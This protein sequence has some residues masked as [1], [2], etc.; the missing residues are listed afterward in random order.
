M[1]KKQHKTKGFFNKIS[2]FFNKNKTD[3][4]MLTI[5]KY[6]QPSMRYSFSDLRIDEDMLFERVK[7]IEGDADFSYSQITNLGKLKSIKGVIFNYNSKLKK[8]DFKEVSK[9]LS[10]PKES[11]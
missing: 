2:Q 8:E 11:D 1:L 7:R 5:L 4:Q 10:I 9:E 3:N 6:Q